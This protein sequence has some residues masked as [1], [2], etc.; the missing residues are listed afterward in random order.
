MAGGLRYENVG[1][2]PAGMRQRM[3]AQILAKVRLANPAPAGPV[4][5]IW[6]CYGKGGLCA[7][8]RCEG[9]K[10][11]CYDGRGARKPKEEDLE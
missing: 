2:M 3:V 8:V 5:E 10:C 6:Y 11:P 7:A 1:R 9:T 4:M